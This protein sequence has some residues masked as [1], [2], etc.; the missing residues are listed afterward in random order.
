MDELSVTPTFVT[1]ISTQH[2]FEAIYVLVIRWLGQ[3]LRVRSRPEY[4]TLILYVLNTSAGNSDSLAGYF[5][6]KWPL[7]RAR[8]CTMAD[9]SVL[10]N[11]MANL[12]GAGTPQSAKSVPVHATWGRSTPAPPDSRNVSMVHA[13]ALDITRRLCDIG[14]NI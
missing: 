10:Q 2:N 12:R 11:T 3:A 5:L 7:S 8:H 13:P 14:G 1:A 6:D 4:F 9:F